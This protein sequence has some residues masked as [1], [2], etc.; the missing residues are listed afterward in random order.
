MIRG[1]VRERGLGGPNYFA[2][3]G[4]G[5][6]LLNLTNVKQFYRNEEAATKGISLSTCGIPKGIEELTRDDSINFLLYISLHTPYDKQR[7]IIMPINKIHSIES[8]L[9]SGRD[10][11]KAKG[12]KTILTYMA[13]P[14][15]NMDNGSIHRLGEIVDPRYFSVQ[16]TCFNG[17]QESRDISTLENFRDR[18]LEIMTSKGIEFDFQMSRGGDVGGGCGQLANRSSQ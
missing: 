6:P 15:V 1:D 7:D 11:A 18:L 10:H 5:E 2:L 9:A 12:R 14:E 3:M 8:V 4:M 16:L 13:L 17:A